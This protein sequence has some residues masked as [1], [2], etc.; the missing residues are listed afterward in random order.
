MFYDLAKLVFD[1]SKKNKFADVNFVNKAINIIVDYYKINDYIGQKEVIPHLK[2]KKSFKGSSYSFDD[3]KIVIDLDYEIKKK[4][5]SFTNYEK[6]HL[7]Y[8]LEIIRILFHELDHVILKKQ[9]VLKENTI[10]IILSKIIM[11]NYDDLYSI[12]EKKNMNIEYYDSNE[13]L[14]R[15]LTYY[16]SYHNMAP[17]E[18]R[19]NI[20][21]TLKVKEILLLLIGTTLNNKIKFFEKKYLNKY[22]KFAKENYKLYKEYLFTNSPSFD[23]LINLDRKNVN[24][25]DEIQL[26]YEN[27]IKSF[28]NTS[29]NYSIHHKIIYGLQLSIDELKQL[30]NDPEKTLLKR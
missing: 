18:R 21:S 5:Y 4:K 11:D 10:D 14:K 24:S 26:Y 19:A 30:K 28:N 16:Y 15:M 7:Y 22:V 25:M 9:I 20:N 27:K 13:R 17:F 8:N 2:E 29:K 23:Y 6:I 3:Q 12:L 1:Y